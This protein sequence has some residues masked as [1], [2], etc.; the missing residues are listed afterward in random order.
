M[1]SVFVCVVVGEHLESE[2]LSK[3][4]DELG[5]CGHAFNEMRTRPELRG[6]IR[7]ERERRTWR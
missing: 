7:R 2:R 5:V 4:S 1:C 3:Q 6:D